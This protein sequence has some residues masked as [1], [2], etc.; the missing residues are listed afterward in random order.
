L[1]Q[2]DAGSMDAALSTLVEGG[3]RFKCVRVA[4]VYYVVVLD[5]THKAAA[6]TELSVQRV[7]DIPH[8]A[9]GPTGDDIT[10]D[11]IDEALE[12]RGLARKVRKCVPFNSIVLM[13]V[14]SNRPA[15]A[16]GRLANDLARICPRV[17]KEL[18]SPTPRTALLMN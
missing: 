14:G 10:D 5:R 15:V 18:P 16:P 8:V 7:A 1:D 4:D 2:L 13:L 6:D 12:E 3:K 17:V 9:I 11:F